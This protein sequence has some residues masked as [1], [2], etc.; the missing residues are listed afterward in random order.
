M[1]STRGKLQSPNPLARVQALQDLSGTRDLRE[2]RWLLL[3]L[4]DPVSSVRREAAFGLRNASDGSVGIRLATMLT[5]DPDEDARV[6]AA[7]A[8]GNSRVAAPVQTIA[9][10]LRDSSERVRVAACWALGQ[11]RDRRVISKLLSILSDESTAVRWQACAA[12]LDTGFA[13]LEVVKTIRELLSEPW[14]EQEEALDQII[15]RVRADPALAH[16]WPTELGDP[17]FRS[18]DRM[19]EDAQRLSEKQREDA[20]QP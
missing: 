3:A 12:L 8:L 20:E 13:N 2:Q 17:E 19:V 18:L 1:E 5:E 4:S 10:A 9:E 16:L 14:Q 11:Y 7:F 6:Y 15:G